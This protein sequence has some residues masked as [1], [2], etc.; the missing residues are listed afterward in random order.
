MAEPTAAEEERARGAAGI[1]VLVGLGAFSFLLGRITAPTMDVKVEMPRRGGW[2]GID[3]QGFR[4]APT[5]GFPPGMDT[6]ILPSS[7]IGMLDEGSLR[8]FGPSTP[9]GSR[10]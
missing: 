4:A 7:G 1:L 10:F 8:E 9:L 5:F 2:D 6:P 3:A